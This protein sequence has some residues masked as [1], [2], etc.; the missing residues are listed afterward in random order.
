M[1]AAE[2]QLEIGSDTWWIGAAVLTGILT[3]AFGMFAVIVA[4]PK[5]MT[6][7]GTDVNTVQWAMTGYLIARAVPTPAMGWLVT[8]LGKR[9]L[10]LLGVIGM[11]GCSSL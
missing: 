1:R 7:F 3:M 4:I 11:T 8:L 2:E 9:R 6:V 10:F 5:V